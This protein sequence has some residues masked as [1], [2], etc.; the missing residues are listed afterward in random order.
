MAVLCGDF[1]GVTVAGVP[2]RTRVS[3][4]GGL[5]MAHDPQRRVRKLAMAA[6]GG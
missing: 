6:Q 1:G 4:N 3:P 2:C 5:C